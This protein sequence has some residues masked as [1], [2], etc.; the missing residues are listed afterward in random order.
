MKHYRAM[1]CRLSGRKVKEVPSYKP[2]VAERASAT[3]REAGTPKT[4]AA[5]SELAEIRFSR[6]IDQ[7][8]VYKFW[9][10]PPVVVHIYTQLE[11]DA[12]KAYIIL[13]RGI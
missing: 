7:H 8:R 5:S 13:H 9:S 4:R 10:L 2:T 11:F 12:D 3:V 1:F 6:L